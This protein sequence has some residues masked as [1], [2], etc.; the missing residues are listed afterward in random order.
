MLINILIVFLFLI[1]SVLLFWQISNLVAICSGCLYVKAN[2][3]NVR[4]V[5]ND[6]AKKDLIF[7][8]LGSGNGDVLMLA[9]EFKMKTFGFE[10]APFYYFESRWRTIFKKDIQV[11]YG[12]ILKADISSADIIYCYLL[13]PLLQKLSSKFS[14]ELKKNA[15]LISAGFPIENLK[16]IR[17]YDIKSRKFFVYKKF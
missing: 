9:D 11:K 8:D 4:T 17:E 14:L 1:A 12:N 2:K 7:Y 10:I 3:A 13:P 15:V 16:L 5:L 6:F